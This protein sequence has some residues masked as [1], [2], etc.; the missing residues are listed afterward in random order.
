MTNNNY[1]Q[2]TQKTDTNPIKYRRTNSCA[3]EG[4]DIVATQNVMPAVLR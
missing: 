1:R 3:P 4:Y 2:Q